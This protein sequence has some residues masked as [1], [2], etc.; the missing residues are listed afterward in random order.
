MCLAISV[1]C[2]MWLCR[3]LY[4]TLFGGITIFTKEQFWKINGFSNMYWG[5][6]AEDDDLYKRYVKISSTYSVQGEMWMVVK[7]VFLVVF[8]S[9]IAC[10]CAVILIVNSF[11]NGAH[12]TSTKKFIDA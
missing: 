10:Y 5:W 3:L 1:V 4:A 11:D 8:D 2:I 9:K 7:T 12:T 6:G